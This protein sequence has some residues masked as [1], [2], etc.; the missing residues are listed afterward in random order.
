[1]R[2]RECSEDQCEHSSDLGHRTWKVLT[3]CE[4]SE[5]LGD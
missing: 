1:M 2:L 5:A 4:Y 3:Y